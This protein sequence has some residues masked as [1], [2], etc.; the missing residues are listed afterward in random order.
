MVNDDSSKTKIGAAED[1]TSKTLSDTSAWLEDLLRPL[2]GTPVLYALVVG[3]SLL[4]LLWLVH[5]FFRF[6]IVRPLA[7]SRVFAWSRWV[8]ATDLSDTRVLSSV[9]TLLSVLVIGIFVQ[10][11]PRLD[12]HFVVIAERVIMAIGVFV[13]ARLV[14]RCGRLLDVVY[15]RFPSVNRPGALRG[16]VS[17]G[18]FLVYITALVLVVS[19][20]MDRSPLYFLTGLGALS[21]ILLI[22]FR[23]TLLS[24]F[25]N[26]IVTTGDLVRV[27]DWIQ[28]P[29]KNA[30]GY[31]IDVSLNVVKV[32]NFDKT[33]AVLP[34][35][36]LVQESF[37]NYRGMYNAG[38]RR[39]KRSILL[40]QRTIRSVADAELESLARLPLMKEAIDLERRAVAAAAPGDLP[41]NSGLFRQY[42]LAYVQAH[43]HIHG[44]PFTILVRHLDPTPEGLPLQVYCFADDTAWANY[45][46]IQATI[47]DHLFSVLPAFGLRVYQSE[48]DFSEPDTTN[49][50]I[51]FDPSVMVGGSGGEP[52][53]GG[54]PA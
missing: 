30:D 7:S 24:M 15:S 21:A 29:G 47:F 31:V 17:V 42:V 3:G 16:Y 45:E 5:L 51:E 52:P 41:T 23:D 27:G 26:V 35:Y 49:R 10:F 54:V 50:R 18:A 4:L 19:V 33:I 6:M 53:T 40:D 14:V 34:T 43:P 1:A 8:S 25:A 13:G 20:L 11:L 36:T 48:S 12:D 9:S 38:G 39:I 28:V 44:D 22:V 37:V 46:A 32:Q 2:E